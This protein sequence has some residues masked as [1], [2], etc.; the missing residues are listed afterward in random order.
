[1]VMMM[2]VNSQEIPGELISQLDDHNADG[3]LT[4]L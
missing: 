1:M 3:T 4:W 2:V